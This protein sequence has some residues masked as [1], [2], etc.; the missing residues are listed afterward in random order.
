MSL[1]IRPAVP[2][3]VGIVAEFNRLLALESE[4]IILDLAVLTAGV[5]VALADP[6]R[7]RYFLAE[8][9]GK[10]V[11]Q[12]MFT[13][14][15]SDWRNGWLWWLQSVYVHAD[16]RRQGVFRALFEHIEQMIRQDPQVIGLRLYVEH[17]N[18]GAQE[19]YAQ[20][21][22]VKSRYFVLEKMPKK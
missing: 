13:R 2:A 19:T 12:V 22:M 15:W 1:V 8:Q 21:G 6:D 17:E 20:V 11:G 7:A 14:E 10:I 4:D 9:D 3:D 16:H 5:A 18:T